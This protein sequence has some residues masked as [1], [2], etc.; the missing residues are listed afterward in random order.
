VEFK[1]FLV[2]IGKAVPAWFGFLA[3]QMICRGVYE[4]AQTPAKGSPSSG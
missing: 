3:S 4:S 1:K 2:A